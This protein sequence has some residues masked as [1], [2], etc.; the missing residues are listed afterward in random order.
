[1][2]F[3]KIKDIIAEQLGIGDSSVMQLA[4]A[5]AKSASSCKANG[6]FGFKM[7]IAPSKAFIL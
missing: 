4:A 2:V 5:Y 1:M 6:T 3:E 7:F